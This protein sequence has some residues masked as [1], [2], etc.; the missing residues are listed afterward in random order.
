MGAPAIVMGDKIQGVCAIHQIPN[1]ASGVPQPGPPMPFSAPITIGTVA[2]VQIGGKPAA[3]MG[4]SG[5]NTPPHVGLHA[6]DPYMA[7]PTQIGRILAGSATVMI[8]GQP[9]ATATSQCTCCV[10][11]GSLVPTVTTVLIG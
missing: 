8:G 5:M 7:P 3:V 11:P 6:T 10:T 1:P 9:A 2:T 4:C